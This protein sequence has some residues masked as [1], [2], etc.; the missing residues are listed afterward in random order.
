VQ[1][2]GAPGV[3]PWARGMFFPIGVNAAINLIFSDWFY[4]QTYHIIDGF[5]GFFLLNSD[6]VPLELGDSAA[7]P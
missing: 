4:P 1:D 2:A 3:Y 6:C 5:F 7:L